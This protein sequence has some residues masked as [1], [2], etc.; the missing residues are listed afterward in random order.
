MGRGRGN[1]LA[2]KTKKDNRMVVTWQIS[3]GSWGEPLNDVTGGR[4]GRGASAIS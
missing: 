1:S 4:S 2:K 3:G